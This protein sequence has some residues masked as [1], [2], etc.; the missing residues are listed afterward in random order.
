MECSTVKTY[1]ENGVCSSSS[2]YFVSLPLTESSGAS[3]CLQ[4]NGVP[5]QPQTSRLHVGHLT[6]NVTEAHIKEIFANFGTVKSVDLALDKIVMLPRGFAYVEFET[7]DDAAN[8][9]LHMDGGQL[10]GNILR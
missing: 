8:A 1:M 9:K 3:N 6:R 5:E 2:C 4:E 7:K 10:D